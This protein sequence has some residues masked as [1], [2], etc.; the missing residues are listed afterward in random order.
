VGGNRRFVVVS[1][2]PGCGK[3]TVGRRIAPL[4]EL[5]LI[6]KD[7]FLEQLLDREPKIDSDV[8][9]GLSRQADDELR[10]SAESSKGAVLVSFW[11]RE[12][13]STTSGTPTTWLRALPNVIEL[14]CTCSPAIAMERFR[15]RRRHAGH[16]DA[17]RNRDALVNQFESL[18][19]LG[20]LGVGRLVRVDTGE[21]VDVDAVIA[22][23][24]AR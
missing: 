17:T 9:F 23:L 7:D 4:L 13:L 12:E 20:P 15:S 11:R 18:A 5:E 8:R 24:S 19:A 16:L 1:G 3:S 14:Y 22:D 2:L 6:D 10:A 21:A